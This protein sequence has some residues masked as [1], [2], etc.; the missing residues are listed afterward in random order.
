MFKKTQ[1]QETSYL[2]LQ[3]IMEITTITQ[4]YVE[5]VILKDFKIW[6][7]FFPTMSTV[8]LVYVLNLTQGQ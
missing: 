2:A 5:H 1:G 7:S 6:K 4:L 8:Q 3:R